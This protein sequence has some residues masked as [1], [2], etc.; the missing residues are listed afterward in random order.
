M[1][2]TNV[3]FGQIAVVFGIVIAGVWS[4]TQWTAAALGW[5]ARVDPQFMQVFARHIKHRPLLDV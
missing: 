2:G 5:G 4:A 1:Q 3:L